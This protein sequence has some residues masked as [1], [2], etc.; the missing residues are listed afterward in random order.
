M[1]YTNNWTLVQSEMENWSFGGQVPNLPQ[2]GASTLPNGDFGICNQ[3][4]HRDYV[5]RIH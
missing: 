3:Y 4:I 1:D 5:T 2:Q